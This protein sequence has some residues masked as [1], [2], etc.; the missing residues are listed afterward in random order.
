[1]AKR[2]YFDLSEACDEISKAKGV[3]ETSWASL[4]LVAKGLYNVGVYA[5]TEGV[6]RFIQTTGEKVLK[7]PSATQEEK[8]NAEE[9]IAFSQE[10]C[11]NRKEEDDEWE[12]EKQDRNRD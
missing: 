5:V 12:R 11:A 2:D 1:M 4:S 8:D 3:S 7:D 10:R 6:D 9:L